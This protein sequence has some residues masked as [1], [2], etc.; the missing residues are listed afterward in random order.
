MKMHWWD[1]IDVLLE[2][3]NHAVNLINEY[4]NSEKYFLDPEFVK[5]RLVTRFF[6]LSRLE[7]WRFIKLTLGI[8]PNFY[9]PQFTDHV[10]FTPHSTVSLGLHLKSAILEIKWI[11]IA[12]PIIDIFNNQKLV[13]LYTMLFSFIPK[14]KNVVKVYNNPQR[15]VRLQMKN[16]ERKRKW[17][18]TEKIK[19]AQKKI[20]SDN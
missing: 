16:D 6:H 18:L 4:C 13:V 20:K 14:M 5:C 12:D 2:R 7:A 1:K 10:D 9:K 8:A 11:L 19:D 17:E 15:F 3:L